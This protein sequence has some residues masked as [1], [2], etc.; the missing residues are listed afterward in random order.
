MGQAIYTK[1]EIEQARDTVNL[2]EQESIISNGLRTFIEVGRALA[3]I[4]DG[5]LY[6]QAGFKTFE[7]Y[8][9]Q[10][11]D[12]S[13]SRAYQL[14]DASSFSTIVE[15]KPSSESQVRPLL[16]LPEPDR[17]KAWEDAVATAPDGKV[18]AKHVAKVVS[19]MVGKKEPEAFHLLIALG[20]LR[21]S[22]MRAVDRWPESQRRHVPQALRDIA[23][24]VAK[25]C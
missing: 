21:D 11:W 25:L 9:R 7:D 10:R 17:A 16:K 1:S 8:C 19:G 20:E 6:V 23:D 5:R 4:R 2:A 24:E 3:R 12:M 15:S 18:T 14:I 13:G 22:I